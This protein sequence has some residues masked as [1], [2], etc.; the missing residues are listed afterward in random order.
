MLLIQMRNIV[1]EKYGVAYTYPK[2]PI[3][4]FVFIT[5][6]PVKTFFFHLEVI[7]K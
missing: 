4:N 3:K 2:N 1:I 5:A 7:G 6:M